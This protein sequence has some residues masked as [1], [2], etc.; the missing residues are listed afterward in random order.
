MA[1]GTDVGVYPV[2]H[3]VG[4]KRHQR[5]LNIRIRRDKMNLQ[6]RCLY[7]RKES[8]TDEDGITKVVKRWKDWRDADVRNAEELKPLLEF[9]K[10]SYDANQK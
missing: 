7:N 10:Q 4:F 8:F 1:L 5:F 3:Y 6:I 2:K 9:I